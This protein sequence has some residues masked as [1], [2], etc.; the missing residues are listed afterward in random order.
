MRRGIIMVKH[1]SSYI[2][3]LKNFWKTVMYQLAVTVFCPSCFIALT[4][5]VLL[6]KTANITFFIARCLFTFAE[7]RSSLKINTLL[8]SCTLTSK[9]GINFSLP[10][11]ILEMMRWP[12]SFSDWRFF[13]ILFYFY[14]FCET[15]LFL[16]RSYIIRNPTSNYFFHM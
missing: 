12:S 9:N 10:V 7:V 14:S 3:F 4:S 5:S 2:H 11:T 6:K 8:S 1:K 16:V 13:F 15:L